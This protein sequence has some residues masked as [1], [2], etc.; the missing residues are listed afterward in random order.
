MWESQWAAVDLARCA[1]R[2][3]RGAEAARLLHHARE[4]ATDLGAGAADRGGRRARGPAPTPGRLHGPLVS[5]HRTGIRGGT[6]H[7]RRPD[8][9]RDRRC[10][11]RHR[12]DRRHP[13]RTHPAQARGRTARRDRRLGGR[14]PD[15]TT[16]HRS[17]GSVTPHHRSLHGPS[18]GCCPDVDTRPSTQPRPYDIQL[19]ALFGR[20]LAPSG[21]HG[22]PSRA[23]RPRLH[24]VSMETRHEVVTP[25]VATQAAPTEAKRPA[26]RRPPPPPGGRFG[27]RR[28]QRGPHLPGGEPSADCRVDRPGRPPP[29]SLER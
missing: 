16:R 21:G 28:G 11:A 29:Y 18:I 4:V 5:T 1:Y 15:R 14:R 19:L 26:R 12:Q 27:Q 3:N 6:T 22:S 17:R 2:S 23:N 13:R 7:H 25:I 10:T 9:P 20:P 8:K 24:R